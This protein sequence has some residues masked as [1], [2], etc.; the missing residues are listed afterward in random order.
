MN[1]TTSTLLYVV[2]GMDFDNENYIATSRVYGIYNNKHLAECLKEN[3]DLTIDNQH[4]IQI[5]ET[6][7]NAE[8]DAEIACVEY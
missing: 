8:C 4:E 3:L 1:N 5:I 6:S 7:V 2:A